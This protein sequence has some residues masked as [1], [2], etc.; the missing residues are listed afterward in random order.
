VSG[1]VTSIDEQLCAPII[2][3]DSLSIKISQDE[4]EKGVED[5][6]SLLHDRI[7]MRKGEKHYTAKELYLKLS[8]LWK[9]LGHWKLVS[10]GHGFFEF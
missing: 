9:L 6:K 7:V 8:K 3:R 4:Y 1:H 10:L 5:W 2:T